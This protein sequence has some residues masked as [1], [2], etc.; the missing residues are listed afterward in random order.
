MNWNTPMRL[1]WDAL[2]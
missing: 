2:F 1:L